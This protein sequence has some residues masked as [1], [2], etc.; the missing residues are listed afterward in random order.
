MSN[1]CGLVT[2]HAGQKYESLAELTWTNNRELYAKKHGYDA[3]AKT[4]DLKRTHLNANGHTLLGYEKIELLLELL[5]AGN[6]DILHWSGAD[7]MITN[8]KIPLPEF[9]YP[10]YSVVIATDFNSINADSFILFNTPDAK[11][12]LQ[13]LLDLEPVYCNK[14]AI[15]QDAMCDI[16]EEFKNIVKIVPQRYLNSYHYPIYRTRANATSNMDSLGYSGNWQPGDF[17][18]HCPGQPNEIRIELFNQIKDLI[19]Q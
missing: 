4:T 17:L 15:E 18:I 19:I 9:Y 11:R 3:I 7:T 8:F 12:W 1:R 6:H 10:G 5:N 16:Q 14:P 13:R 2:I